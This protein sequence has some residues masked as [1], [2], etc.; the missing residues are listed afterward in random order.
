MVRHK[1]VMFNEDQSLTDE[2]NANEDPK[3]FPAK[4]DNDEDS[5]PSP[6]QGTRREEFY[7]L[8]EELVVDLGD[9]NDDTKAP[10]KGGQPQPQKIPAVA[11][12]RRSERACRPSSHYPP[13]H[14]VMVTDEEEPE[15]YVE[16]QKHKNNK[17]WHQAMTEEMEFL[18]K[19]KTYG[20]VVLPKVKRVLRNKW[21]FKLKKDD[22]SKKLRY[23]AKLV[24]KGFTQRQ[25]VDYDEIFSPVVKMTSDRM[26]LGLV[27]SLDIK[28]EQMDVKTS[29]LHGDLSNKIY[30]EQLEGF[31]KKGIEHLVCKL[32]KSLY[33]L[34]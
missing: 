5:I 30:M 2:D 3:E 1:S 28:V 21:V 24:V 9:T 33:S 25:G 34:K 15:S 14:Y 17:Q 7:P 8:Q 11:S 16:A 12:V 22:G 6:V 18:E 27:A 32:K 20:L 26:V 29:F 10:K 23:K 31:L 19:N 4:D 13:L